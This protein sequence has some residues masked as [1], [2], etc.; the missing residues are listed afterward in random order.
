MLKTLFALAFVTS[1]VIFPNTQIIPQY[2]GAE[3]EEFTKASKSVQIGV[4]YDGTSN[5]LGAQC[6]LPDGMQI[7]NG[8]RIEMRPITKRADKKE[9]PSATKE[10]VGVI[11]R[12]YSG[13]SDK[14]ASG[15]PKIETK[16]TLRSSV[17]KFLGS[18][19]DI[20]YSYSGSSVVFAKKSDEANNSKS[21]K[22]EYKFK[23]GFAAD[24]AVNVNSDFMPPLEI[25]N[26]KETYDPQK[27][28]EIKWK[29][30]E[31]ADGYIVTAT[32]SNAD[33]IIIWS[34]GAEGSYLLGVQN[35]LVTAGV[36]NKYKSTWLMPKGTNSCTIPQGIFNGAK[37]AIVTVTAFGKCTQTETADTI[38]S[39]VLMSSVRAPIAFSSVGKG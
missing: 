2:S 6:F 12:L 34:S 20:E 39:V 28:V 11:I 35:S 15:E 1:R 13:S 37:N 5:S 14:I 24:T 31:G 33:G 32:G 8:T 27:P 16:D 21:A 23:T 29:G 9:D 26:L 10:K 4:S 7:S 19:G 18:A 3:V 25:T 36:I 17:E 22:G 38:T 30:T